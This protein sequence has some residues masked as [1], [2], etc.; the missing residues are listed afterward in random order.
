MW[1]ITQDGN[2]VNLANV[3]ALIL[4]RLNRA[5]YASTISDNS[6]DLEKFETVDAAKNYIVSLVDEL[7]GG[8]KPKLGYSFTWLSKVENLPPEKLDEFNSMVE[9]WL[10]KLSVSEGTL[11]STGDKGKYVLAPKTFNDDGIAW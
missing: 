4:D 6:I 7:N 11:K 5:V 8:K 9:D 1:I 2:A 10:D 3:D